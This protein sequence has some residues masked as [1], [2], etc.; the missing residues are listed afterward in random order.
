MKKWYLCAAAVMFLFML[1]GC[2]SE[3]EN[4]PQPAAAV[5]TKPNNPDPVPAPA[6]ALN[7]L[8]TVLFMGNSHT[9]RTDIL[10]TL[11][12]QNGYLLDAQ[13]IYTGGNVPLGNDKWTN[14]N[15][16]TVEL[17]TSISVNELT[18]NESKSHLRNFMSE[19]CP[20]LLPEGLSWIIVHDGSV[21]NSLTCAGTFMG[22]AAAFGTKTACYES[23][24]AIVKEQSNYAAEKFNMPLIPVG[25][26][27]PYEDPFDPLKLK[28]H[29]GDGHMSDQGAYVFAAMFLHFFSGIAVDDI[30]G[31]A[32][33]SLSDEQINEAKNR[34][35]DALNKKPFDGK[36]Y[37]YDKLSVENFFE[38][39]KQPA[40]L[41]AGK[42][43]T[44]ALDIGQFAV[45][46]LPKGSAGKKILAA[47]SGKTADIAGDMWFYNPKEKKFAAQ[48]LNEYETDCVY[49]GVGADWEIS[50]DCVLILTRRGITENADE[51]AG[52]ESLG[53]PLDSVIEEE[54]GKLAEFELTVDFIDAEP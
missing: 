26:A 18:A 36:Q 34:I 16:Y 48:G 33:L 47:V 4:S 2:N 37:Y 13:H 28:Y 10:N 31:D 30:K 43:K 24:D 8:G 38:K 5:I 40:D 23:W 54:C 45:F 27:I 32:S 19:L 22:L 25:T 52:R 9:F 42:T 53:V 51:I 29:V 6:S 21:P 7:D 49:T 15:K 12:K 11:A 50:G 46:A 20:D 14:Q 1:G 35:K 17:F 44:A 3:T 39:N 41:E